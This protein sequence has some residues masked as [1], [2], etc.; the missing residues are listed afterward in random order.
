MKRFI[1]AARC[2]AIMYGWQFRAVL[3]ALD[4]FY[5]IWR[6]ARYLSRMDYVDEGLTPAEALQ[7]EASCA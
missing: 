6:C 7:E 1:W 5:G 2:A 4:G 3:E